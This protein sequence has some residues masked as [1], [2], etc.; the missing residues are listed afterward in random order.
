[1]KVAI[2]HVEQ[3]RRAKA[4]LGGKFV[5]DYGRHMYVKFRCVGEDLVID[6]TNI[7][8]CGFITTPSF[9]VHTKLALKMGRIVLSSTHSSEFGLGPNLQQEFLGDQVPDMKPGTAWNDKDDDDG[10]SVFWAVNARTY[11]DLSMSCS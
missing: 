8:H 2:N 4:V 11:L 10:K 7:C 5:N 1:M 6:N 9:A 3:Q